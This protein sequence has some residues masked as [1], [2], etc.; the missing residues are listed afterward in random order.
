MAK[1]KS[2]KQSRRRCKVPKSYKPNDVYW[3]DQLE[4]WLDRFGASTCDLPEIDPETAESEKQ[5]RYGELSRQRF[6]VRRM[7]QIDKICD[8]ETAANLVCDLLMRASLITD[9]VTWI[10]INKR[11]VP[12]R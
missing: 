5:F 1:K 12:D 8:G 10:W 4:H 11:Y 3:A 7:R 6:L 9:A 2:R